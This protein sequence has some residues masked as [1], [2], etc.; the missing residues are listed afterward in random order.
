MLTYLVVCPNKL[1]LVG[2]ILG[3]NRAS[4]A[5]GVSLKT[6]RKGGLGEE[7]KSIEVTTGG[8]MRYGLSEAQTTRPYG[9]AN[10]EIRPTLATCD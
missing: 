2:R 6:L 8:H 4:R 3:I 7:V 5:L 10:G 9:R 1:L